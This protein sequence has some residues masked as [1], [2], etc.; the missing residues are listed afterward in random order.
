[1]VGF[2]QKKWSDE[3]H[4]K[5]WGFLGIG[6]SGYTFKVNRNS[7][8]DS[9]LDMLLLL[10]QESISSKHLCETDYTETLLKGSMSAR[11]LL[12][13]L[14]PLARHFEHKRY[15]GG[16][17]PAELVSHAAVENEIDLC[18]V[19]ADAKKNIML[20]PCNHMC[21]CKECANLN[22]FKYCPICRTEVEGSN[23]VF[24]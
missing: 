21:L 17:I 15:A 4:P 7:D 9:P 6:P 13:M 16:E 3:I 24:W 8:A 20:L 23:V 5:Y 22:R 11:W 2:L 14:Q 10:L 12:L 1:M 19:C 18:I